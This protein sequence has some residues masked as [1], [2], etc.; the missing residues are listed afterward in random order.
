MPN[1]SRLWEEGLPFARVQGNEVCQVGG[2]RVVGS[3]F[4]QPGNRRRR[5]PFPGWL[6]P[7]PLF[8]QSRTSA[9]GIVSPTF[10]GG[11][12]LPQ[13]K[14]TKT[15]FTDTPKG[16][17]HEF[18]VFANP[19]KLTMEFNYHTQ[20]LKQYFSMHTRLTRN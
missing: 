5:I 8:S 12:F 16:V 1:K 7:F 15:T 10:K 2:R 4:I 13:L 6:S 17:P 19:T 3:G 14:I 11:G 20:Y 18:S 9:D